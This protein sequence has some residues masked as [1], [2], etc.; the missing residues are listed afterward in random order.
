MCIRDSLR[1]GDSRRSCDGGYRLVMQGDGNLVLYVEGGAALWSSDTFGTGSDRAV[2]QGD[3]NFVVYDATN[4][5][6]FDTGTQSVG[7]YLAVQGDGNL[8]VYSA[9]GAPLWASNTAQ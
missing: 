9:G 8:V 5:P 4:Q 2:M 7:A 3:G 6:H 1:V